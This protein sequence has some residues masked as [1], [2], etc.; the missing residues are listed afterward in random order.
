MG[1]MNSLSP[2]DRKFYERDNLWQ[3]CT[4]QGVTKFGEVGLRFEVIQKLLDAGLVDVGR[5][6]TTPT[7]VNIDKYH[8]APL[9]LDYVLV[10]T[11]LVSRVRGFTVI[12]DGVTGQMSDH[13]PVMVQLGL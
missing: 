4:K 1:D 13:Y 11:D 2:A 12:R 8:L 6:Y 5:G 3:K 9:R 10:S 7:P